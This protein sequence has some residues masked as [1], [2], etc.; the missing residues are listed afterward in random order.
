MPHL[1]FSF[2]SFHFHLVHRLSSINCGAW[3]YGLETQFEGSRSAEARL[4]ADK[5]E[6]NEKKYGP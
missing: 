5:R 4:V 2:L 6:V 1:F 3:V